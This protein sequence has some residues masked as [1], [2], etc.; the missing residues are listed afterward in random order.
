MRK[1]TI[2]LIVI[3]LAALIVIP[4]TLFVVDETQLAIV[5][6][7][8]EF[9][10]D[11][12]SPGLQVKTPFAEQVTLF[13]KR[14][15]RVDVAPAS[16]L[17]SDKRN[18]VIDSYARYRI[19]DPLI[20][21][22]NLRNEASA[23]SR[24]GD[25][26]NSQLRQEVAQ[27]LQDEVISEKRENIMDRVTAA[28]NLIELSRSDVIR[29]YNGLDDPFIT[30]RLDDD[31]NDDIRSRRATDA[32]IQAL[33]ADEKALES[34]GLQATYFASVRKAL[35][36]VIVDVRIK[37]ADFP[38]DIESS[39]FSRMEAERER[40]ASGLRAEGSQRDAEIRA[41]VDRQVNIILE[42]AQ[43]TSALLRGEA[44]QEA[45]TILAQALEKN[46]D[47]YAFRRSLEAY[48]AFLDSQTT[49]ILDPDSDL[50]KFLEDPKGN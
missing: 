42:T 11:H 29:D 34:Q 48:K 3:I 16:L 19:V 20:F 39:V 32:E 49:V 14:L 13:D 36:I 12:T 40:I 47:F 18:L 33:I 45:I 28:S 21:Y 9:K 8:G 2:P 22:K 26:V 7:F 6:R 46:P 43:G 31:P 5:T 44:E 4:Q 50:L 24:V 41:E 1:L 38:P 37:R 27:D 25:I 15:L 35:G 30:V 10:R 17:T 23:N